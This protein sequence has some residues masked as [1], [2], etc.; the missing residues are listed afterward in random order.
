MSHVKGFHENQDQS[1]LWSMLNHAILIEKYSARRIGF[2]QTD[3]RSVESVVTRAPPKS[4][5]N[6]SLFSA[7]IYCTLPIKIEESQGCPDSKMP[8]C[9]RVGVGRGQ[10]YSPCSCLGAEF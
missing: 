3:S 7:V 9:F 6:S 5:L 10:E 2:R 1:V 8:P 4:D